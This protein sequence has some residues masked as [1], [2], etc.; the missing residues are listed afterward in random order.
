MMRI[1]GSKRN[2]VTGGWR[3]LHKE[4]LN[5]FYYSPSTIRMF[6]S[7]RM[8][9]EGYVAQMWRRKMHVEYWW[10]RQKERDHQEDQKVGRWIILK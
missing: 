8:R 5:K 9:W 6:N 7:R 10:E 2:Q 1:F 3:K 4:E